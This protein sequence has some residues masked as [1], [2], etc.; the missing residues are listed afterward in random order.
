MSIFSK[1]RAKALACALAAF[2]ATGAHATTVTLADGSL[3]ESANAQTGVGVQQALGAEFNKASGP[4]TFSG[5]LSRTAGSVLGGGSYN[6]GM[7]VGNVYFLVHPGYPNG[8]FRFDSVN[9]TTSLVSPGSNGSNKSIGFTPDSSDIDFMVTL[10]AVGTDYSFD[11]SI[12]QTGVGSFSS[13]YTLAQSAFGTAGAISSF[14]A[15][16]NGRGTG[17]GPISYSDFTASVAPV[18]LPAGLPL[19]LIALGGLGMG[20]RRLRAS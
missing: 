8:A 10:N 12:N 4:M 15:F 9:L 5:T 16:H 3:A 7:T 14:G 19:M 2:A 18:P 20:S 11:V 13:T 17:F 1:L 6:L